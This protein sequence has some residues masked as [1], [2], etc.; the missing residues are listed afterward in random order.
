VAEWI[1]LPKPYVTARIKDQHFRLIDGEEAQVQ[2]YYVF[3][4]RSN[5]NVPPL[6][7]EFTPR[8][9]QR[10]PGVLT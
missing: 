2:P 10:L 8:A 3:L 7:F 4:A 9:V 5:R 1:N 6:A